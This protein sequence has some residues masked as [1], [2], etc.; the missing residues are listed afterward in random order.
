MIPVYR[1][2]ADVPDAGCATQPSA[3]REVSHATHLR[4]DLVEYLVLGIA[5]G[6]ELFKRLLY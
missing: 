2:N 5:A 4:V 6:R 3:R 1:V